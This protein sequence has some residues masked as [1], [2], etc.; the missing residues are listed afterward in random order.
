M[1]TRAKQEPKMTVFGFDEARRVFGAELTVEQIIADG[2]NPRVVD[3]FEPDPIVRT[4]VTETRMS[5]REQEKSMLK[6]QLRNSTRTVAGGEKTLSFTRLRNAAFEMHNHDNDT[7][8]L[9]MHDGRSGISLNGKFARPGIR[10]VCEV[11]FATEYRRY[12]V[13][14]AGKQPGCGR[15]G[16]SRSVMIDNGVF[17]YDAVNGLDAAAFGGRMFHRMPLCGIELPD[18]MKWVF[19]SFGDWHPSIFGGSLRDV[20]RG[21]D[22][23]DVDFMVDDL[24]DF[25]IYKA[26]LEK[27]GA[28]DLAYNGEQY[29][30]HS[31]CGM[32]IGFRFGGVDYHLVARDVQAQDFWNINDFSMNQIVCSDPKLIE[33]S[34]IALEDIG[35]NV[36]RVTSSLRPAIDAE[37]PDGMGS[38]VLEGRWSK[39]IASF[40]ERGISFEETPFVHIDRNAWKELER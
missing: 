28:T 29:F 36:F 21:V 8:V 10:D 14:H 13:A 3:L 20:I 2:I 22:F 39:R 5:S 38:G 11:D 34:N 18:S 26:R 24:D 12:L 16:D 4:V 7:A 37:L 19:E 9:S 6:K 1:A 25:G 33:A 35:N 31:S 15:F 17:H 30:D 32:V 40:I 27:L 23:K